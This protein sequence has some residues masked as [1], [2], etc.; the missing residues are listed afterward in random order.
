MNHLASPL[1]LSE[2]GADMQLGVYHSMPSF[3]QYVLKFEVLKK[4]FETFLTLAGGLTEL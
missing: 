2:E 1:I 3:E 4:E